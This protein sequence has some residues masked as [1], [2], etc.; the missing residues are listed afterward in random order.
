[1]RDGDVVRGARLALGAQLAARRQAADETQ[2]TLAHKLPWSRSTIASVETGRQHAPLAFWKSCDELLNAD[3]ALLDS[4]R[5]LEALISAQASERAETEAAA[6]RNPA[7]PDLGWQSTVNGAVASVIGLSQESVKESVHDLEPATAAATGAVTLRWLLAPLDRQPQR[8]SGHRLVGRN[9]VAAVIAM[10]KSLRQLDNTHGGGAVLHMSLAYFRHDVAPLLN[11]RYSAGIGKALF[12]ATSQLI[13][14]L[15][16]MAY[17]AAHHD[18]A[19]R[20]MIQALRLSH[21][22]GDRSFGGRVLAA[23]SHQAL[24]LGAVNEAIDFARAAVEG[25]RDRTTPGAQAMFAATE[26]RAQALY[27]D[28]QECQRLIGLAERAFDRVQVETEPSWTGF[29]DEGELAGKFGRCFRDLGQT[30]QADSFLALSIQRHK[31]IYPRSRAITQL[32]WA[33]TYVQQNELEEACRLG[34][35]ALVA[36]G[37]IRSERTRDYLRELRHGLAPHYRVSAV[38]DFLEQAR[39]LLSVNR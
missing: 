8:V 11:G 7:Q 29:I 32:I 13:M 37:P 34:N 25:T 9:D 22:A 19:R 39:P 2:R 16:W 18:L 33:S 24:H 4:Y 30:K 35:E 15:A 5:K 17:D 26:A 28:Q 21:A 27:G 23:M 1:V 3:G 38:T 6:G 10:H 14:A 12:A 36:I 31:P 20:V